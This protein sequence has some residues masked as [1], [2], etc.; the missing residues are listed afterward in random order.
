MSIEVY[1][2]TGTGNSLVVARDIAV[3]LDAKLIP[4]A[5]VMHR[6]RIDTEA[7]VTGVVFP[8]YYGEPPLIVQDFL[9]KLSNTDGKYIFAVSTYGGAALDTLR[10]ARRI[11]RSQGAELSA[12][13]GV[14][15]PQ[16]SFPKPKESQEKLY[17]SW[18]S[19]VQAIVENIKLRK[20][21]T[22][23]ERPVLEL[24]MHPIHA[25]AIRR[26]V[27]T[28]F[29]KN[30]GLPSSATMPEHMRAMGK[31]FCVNGRCTGCSICSQV[32]PVMNIVIQGSRPVWLTRCEHC[33]ACYNWC[34]QKAIEGG[35]TSKGYFYR[36][37]DVSTSDLIRQRKVTNMEEGIC[38]KILL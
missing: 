7:E 28:H 1:Y 36:H 16:N 15:M 32:C 10:M 26:I 18:E 9:R 34:P 17:A 35:I 21:G 33:L 19:R 29:R 11:L 14:H 13:Y 37:P 27:R 4:I 12:A 3:R 38:T 25:V 30:S 23:Y 22:F 24:I 5:S 31:N 2:F 20:Q 6:T 8:N